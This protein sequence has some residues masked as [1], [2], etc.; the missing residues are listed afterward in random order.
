MYIVALK[1]ARLIEG[2][3][4]SRVAYYCVNPGY[5]IAHACV[6]RTGDYY[7]SKYSTYSLVKGEYRIF[8]G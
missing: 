5:I 3:S 1:A 7:S 8:R 2:G 6:L 4:Y